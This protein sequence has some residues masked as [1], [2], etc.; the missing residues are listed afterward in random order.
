M[1]VTIS[2]LA[3]ADIEAITD[4]IAR[5]NPLRAVSY[6]KELWRLCLALADT[7]F[8]FAQLQNYEAFGYRRRIFESYSIIYRIEGEEVTIV[9]IISSYMDV[10]VALGRH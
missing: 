5:D 1:Y 6:A 8:R 3:E 4:F 9:R 2:N 10:D 7:P